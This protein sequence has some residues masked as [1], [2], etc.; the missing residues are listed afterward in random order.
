MK[1]WLT[2]AVL[3]VAFLVGIE[4]TV[5]STAMPRVVGDL[6]GMGLYSW[7]FSAYLSCVTLTGLMWG[8]LADRL[9]SGRCYLASILLFLLGSGLC[10]QARS[11]DFLIAARAIQGLGGGGLTPLGQA[12]LAE[13]HDVA[14]RARVQGY[15]VTVFGISSVLGPLLGGIISEYNWRWVFYLNLPFGL[16]GM[17]VILRF[18][19][20]RQTPRE[21]RPFDFLGLLLFTCA[22]GSFLAWCGGSVFM[23]AP[24]VIF[25]L[26]LARSQKKPGGFLPLELL[27]IPYVRNSLGVVLVVGMCV[28]AGINYLPL[29]FQASLGQTAA[30]SGRSMMPLL[31]SWV[32]SAGVAPRLALRWGSRPMVGGAML[33]LL[34]AFALL[35]WGPAGAWSLGLAGLCIGLGGGLS[36]SPIMLSVQQSV[37]RELLGSATSTVSFLRMLGAT[38]GT[39]LLGLALPSLHQ[40]FTIGFGLAVIGALLWT[41]MT[42]ASY[43]SA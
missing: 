10:G 24:F 29:F 31:L 19:P 1:G 26:L 28:F 30:E 23:L 22:M 16:A 4:A 7:V 6:G 38:A 3:L 12:I 13:L 41:R 33:A 21:E 40:S 37:P 43:G 11:M 2:G 17:A 39:A 36:F 42:E 34:T 18:L 5:V 14:G 35:A 25:S 27:E 8:R 15:L 20:T 9:G 32:V